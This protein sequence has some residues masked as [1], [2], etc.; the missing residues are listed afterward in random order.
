MKL[1]SATSSLTAV[2]ATRTLGVT[3]ATLYAYVSRGLIRSEPGPGP[4]RARRYAREDIERLRRRAE[5]RRDPGKVAAH[6][7]EWG[8]PVLESSITLIA[9]DTIYYR[10]H[11]AVALARTASVES[12]ASLIWTGRLD[13]ARPPQRAASRDQ[14]SVLASRRGPF[15]ARAQ[16]ALALAAA[17][18]AQA[19]DLRGDAVVRAGWRILDLLGGAA[20]ARIGEHAI[21]VA[22]ARGWRVRTGGEA[23]VRAAL[24]LCADHELNVSAF[25]ARCVASAGSHPYAVVIAGLAAIEGVKHGGSTARVESLLAAT[26]SARPLRNALTERLRQGFRVEGFGHPLYRHGDPRAA[27]L[28]AMLGE[29]YARSAELR[30]AREFARVGTSLTGEQPNLDFALASVSRVLKLPPGSGLTLFAIG[31]AIGWIGHALEQ[32]ALDRIIRPR[33]RYVGVAPHSRDDAFPIGPGP[34][35]E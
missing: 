6:A 33:A 13:A 12:V 16:S 26:R 10:G 30:F 22:L 27:A 15:V 8:V 1:G 4:S 3:R 28:M 34:G 25:T 24:I 31:R 21:A 14:R 5:E 23:L 17:S 20:G 9:D 35:P 29:Q 18:D 2:E 19:F 7:L 32:Y 11:D